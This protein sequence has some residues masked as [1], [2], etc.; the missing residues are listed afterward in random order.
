MII[1][2]LKLGIKGNFISISITE[3]LLSKPKA[4]S[5]MQQ[6]NLLFLL[7]S[8][9]YKSITLLSSLF[10]L[11]SYKP[12]THDLSHNLTVHSD[13]I[14]KMMLTCVFSLRLYLVSG[15]LQ[16]YLCFM[17]C[18]IIAKFPKNHHVDSERSRGSKRNNTV[19]VNR[20]PNAHKSCSKNKILCEIPGKA[21]HFGRRRGYFGRSPHFN[22]TTPSRNLSTLVTTLGRFKANFNKIYFKT[23]AQLNIKCLLH[24]IFCDKCANFLTRLKYRFYNKLSSQF[25]KLNTNAIVAYFVMRSPDSQKICVFLILS[26][27]AILT[28][29]AIACV[30]AYN[31]VSELVEQLA[32]YAARRMPKNIILNKQVFFKIAYP[33]SAVGHFI[34]CLRLKSLDIDLNRQ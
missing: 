11:H 29:S 5:L 20:R 6:T 10:F 15:P 33:I 26:S 2:N 14:P 8:Y 12:Y 13:V 18:F 32:R 34:F 31:F 28:L 22:H 25:T 3:K 4:V 19:H 30:C 17:T 27:R 23:G 9:T 16:L 21:Y 24:N 1:W 7:T